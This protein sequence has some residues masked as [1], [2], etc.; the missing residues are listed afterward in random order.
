MLHACRE[1]VDLIYAPA[2]TERSVVVLGWNVF[3]SR[4]GQSTHRSPA[5][6]GISC[7]IADSLFGQGENI[8]VSQW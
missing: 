7:I 6:G 8:H 3:A 4:C 2:C 1:E 5:A